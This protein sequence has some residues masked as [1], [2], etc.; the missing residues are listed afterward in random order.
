M[1]F[2]RRQTGFSIYQ[3]IETDTMF[4]HFNIDIKIKIMHLKSY[5]I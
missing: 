1:I 4:T 5:I 3:Q 2:G